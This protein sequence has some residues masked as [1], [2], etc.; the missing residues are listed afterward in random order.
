MSNSGPPSHRNS[1]RST[2]PSVRII[3]DQ[4][5]FVADGSFGGSYKAQSAKS[6]NLYVW[7]V[8]SLLI[9]STALALYDLYLLMSVVAGGS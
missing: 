1:S 2:G 6:Q 7:I 4:P 3:S 5:S 8:L 9:A